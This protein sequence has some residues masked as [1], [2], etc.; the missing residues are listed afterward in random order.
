MLPCLQVNVY[1]NLGKKGMSPRQ[2]TNA[3]QKSS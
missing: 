2:I 1:D 3:I